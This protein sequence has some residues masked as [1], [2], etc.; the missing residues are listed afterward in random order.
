MLSEYLRLKND[1]ISRLTDKKFENTKCINNEFL[2]FSFE[3]VSYSNMTMSVGSVVG[4]YFFDCEFINCIFKN[5]ISFYKSEFHNCRFEN[6][7]F[8]SGEFN[9]CEFYSSVFIGVNWENWSLEWSFFYEI[10]FRK[11]SFS[12]VLLKGT[13]FA[14]CKLFGIQ[15]KK[16]FIDKLNP[17]K[18]DQI[19]L[20]ETGNSLKY[21]TFEEIL[22]LLN[23]TK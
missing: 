1:G 23:G 2:D 5:E 15:S 9:K 16:I 8:E 12:E 19:D 17:P 20:S 14:D 10:D 21:A 22:I 7:S 4:V 18:F 13:M 6:C 3:R 11:N